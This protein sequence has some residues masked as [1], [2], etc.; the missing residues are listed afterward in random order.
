[1]SLSNVA[2]RQKMVM[3]ILNLNWVNFII[4]VI[5]F[6]RMKPKL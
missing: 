1:M 6:L 4:M 5:M 3:L 2:K